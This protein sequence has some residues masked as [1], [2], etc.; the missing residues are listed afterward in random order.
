MLVADDRCFDNARLAEAGHAEA[1]VSLV[2]ELAELSETLEALGVPCVGV[3][4]NE[5]TCP[6][7]ADGLRRM[8]S[9]I[10]GLFTWRKR[11]QEATQ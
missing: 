5:L 2:D 11:A 8:L 3:I 1:L 4:V 6:A 9:R 10:R 7:P